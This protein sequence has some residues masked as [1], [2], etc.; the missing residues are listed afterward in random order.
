MPDVQFIHSELDVCLIGG[1]GSMWPTLRSRRF[2]AVITDGPSWH[3][4]TNQ[5]YQTPSCRHRLPAVFKNEHVPLRWLVHREVSKNQLKL[6]SAL[7]EDKTTNNRSLGEI[8]LKFITCSLAQFYT[9]FIPTSILQ[10]LK[11]KITNKNNG[12]WKVFLSWSE[13]YSLKTEAELLFL[14]VCLKTSRRE[15]LRRRQ[16]MFQTDLALLII[17]QEFFF[18]LC[19][20]AAEC[21][22]LEIKIVSR[23]GKQDA[24]NTK[25]M[26]DVENGWNEM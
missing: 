2:K 12:S 13:N 11:K 24:A 25:M 21:L 16:K 4:V 1:Q 15:D 3:P 18:F 17:M 7:R 6:A 22:I 23:R 8:F 10:M 14:D 19:S 5:P 9:W 20:E 26:M